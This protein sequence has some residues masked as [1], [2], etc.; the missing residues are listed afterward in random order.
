MKDWNMLEHLK[1]AETPDEMRAAI[2][3]LQHY[4][5]IVR[6]VMVSANYRGASAEDRYTVLA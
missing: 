3:R 4:D 6:A 1:D 5:P 2:Y